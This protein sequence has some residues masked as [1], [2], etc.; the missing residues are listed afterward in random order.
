MSGQ[1]VFGFLEARSPKSRTGYACHTGDASPAY[2]GAAA[3]AQGDE[4]RLEIHNA[5]KR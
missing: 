5:L 1:R 4:N 2:G 3:I